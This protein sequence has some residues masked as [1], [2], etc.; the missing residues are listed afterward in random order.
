MA[1]P[2]KIND[3][4]EDA[5]TIRY[6]KLNLGFHPEEEVPLVGGGSGLLDD[7]I[8]METAQQ[9]AAVAGTD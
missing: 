4:Q 9:G 7:A 3:V 5:A 2:R 1:P 6:N 8:K